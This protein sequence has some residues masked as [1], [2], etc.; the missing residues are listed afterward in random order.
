MNGN[1][2]SGGAIPRHQS[3]LAPQRLLTVLLGDYWYARREPLPSRAL[4]DLLGVME[5][6]PSS[7]RAAIQR[8]AARGLLVAHKNGRY[9]SYSVHA[10][11]QQAISERVQR[12]F[13]AHREHPWDGTWTIITYRVPETAAPLRRMVR[14]RLRQLHFGHLNDGVWIKPGQHAEAA[15]AHLRDGSEPVL[16]LVSFFEGAQLPSFVSPHD[17]RRAFDADAR[18]ELYLDFALSWERR[19]QQLADRWPTGVEALRLR[20]EALSEWRILV[21][22]DPQ[23]PSAMMPA[24]PPLRRAAAVAARFYDGLG[25]A[26][27]RAVRTILERHSPELAPL[28]SHHTF[29]DSDTL[30][31]D[32]EADTS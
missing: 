29:A 11:S 24:E 9:T 26:A 2:R 28:V 31:V 22:Q 15:F 25:H 7:A 8:L 18:D 12:L 3:G 17:L 21:R 13:Q 14:E 20:T 5:V 4:V 10:G 6:S 1:S 23:L 27:E 19:A 30:L 16:N 32:S